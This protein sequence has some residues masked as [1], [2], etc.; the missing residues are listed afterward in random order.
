MQNYHG[1]SLEQVLVSVQLIQA[2]RLM[3]SRRSGAHLYS[4]YVCRELV[5]MCYKNK[6]KNQKVLQH[7]L[8]ASAAHKLC[9]YVLKDR[10][11]MRLMEPSNLQQ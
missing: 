6:A 3:Q 11:Y 8:D 7:S 2:G 10:I 5:F 1:L 4:W 9:A